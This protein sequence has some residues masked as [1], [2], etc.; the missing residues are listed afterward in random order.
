[1]PRSGAPA[2]AFALKRPGADRTAVSALTPVVEGAV[3]PQ[4][5]TGAAASIGLRSPLMSFPKARWVKPAVLVDAE[6][7]GKTSEALL[8]HP[9]FKGFRDDL[10]GRRGD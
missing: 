10:M 5:C 3:L 6:F 1:M 4:A 8:R 7:R 9:S 2:Q